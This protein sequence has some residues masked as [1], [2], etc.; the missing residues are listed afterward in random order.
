MESSVN[1]PESPSWDSLLPRYRQYL[2]SG[3]LSPRT[4]ELRLYHLNRIRKFLDKKPGDVLLED[5]T[6]YFQG[7]SWAPN[8]R[9]VVRACMSVFYKWATDNEYLLKNPAARLMSVRVP[10]GKPK[11]ASDDALEQALSSASEKVRLMVRLGERCGLRAMEIAAISTHDLEQDELGWVLRVLGKG[12]KVR[13]IPIGDDF[14][15]ELLDR[16]A[17]FVFPGAIDGHVSPAYVSRLVSSVLP[18]GV[19]AHKLRHRFATK[20]LR[21]SNNN[22]RA[23]QELL[24][25]SSIATTQIYTGIGSDQ[26]RQAAL[27]AS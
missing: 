13:L 18:A 7:R 16:K 15:A 23:V 12:S 2:E 22:L 14:A 3:T 26:L 19:T 27:S 21:G 5:L 17:G 4:V 9:A 24:G 11:P 25:H 1:L 10:Q 20:A 8:T 6:R